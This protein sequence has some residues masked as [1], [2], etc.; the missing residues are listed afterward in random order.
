M[1]L[2]RGEYMWPGCF[3]APVHGAANGFEPE[4]KSISKR[5]VVAA[6][7]M[8]PFME[9]LPTLRDAMLVSSHL[10]AIP[11]NRASQGLGRPPKHF[12][13]KC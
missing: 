4:A 9:A 7:D 3:Q 5:G 6:E 10:R 2:L 11:A 1:Q 13:F 8:S 12:V